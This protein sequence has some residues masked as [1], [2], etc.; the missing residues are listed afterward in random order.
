MLGVRAVLALSFEQIHRWNLIGMGILPLRLPDGL[1]PD[2]L[3]LGSGD[4]I[5][6]AADPARVDP[7]CE[8]GVVVKRKDGQQTNLVATAAM[9]TN[10]EVEILRAGGILPLILNK[11]VRKASTE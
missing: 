3:A 5:E 8:I 10:A 2:E 6:I 7:R 4:V 1:G 9:E 11:A